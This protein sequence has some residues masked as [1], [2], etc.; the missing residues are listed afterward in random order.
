MTSVDIFLSRTAACGARDHF[1]DTYTFTAS[2]KMMMSNLVPHLV[3]IAR[4]GSAAPHRARRRGR[5]R[6]RF[7]TAGF[8]DYLTAK[9]SCFLMIPHAVSF[10]SNKLARGTNA[11]SVLSSSTCQPDRHPRTPRSPL[12]RAPDDRLDAMT[13]APAPA[14]LSARGGLCAS[15]QLIVA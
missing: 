14:F 4:C 3:G 13:R 7:D 1:T 8:F 2:A 9:K 15:T 10:L 11:L 6:I 5:T 12:M